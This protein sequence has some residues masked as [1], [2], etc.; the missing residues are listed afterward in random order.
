MGVGIASPA[1]GGER[2]GSRRKGNLDFSAKEG[3]VSYW[4]RARCRPMPLILHV[5]DEFAKRY[6][7]PMS[8]PEGK[9]S[10]TRRLD[11]WSA[12]HFR[13]GRKPYVLA[14]NDASLM[15]IL[16]PAT[17]VT[18]LKKFF[19][20]FLGRVAEVWAEFGAFFDAANQ[21]VLFLPRNNQS[22][23]ESMKAALLL[24][25]LEADDARY[26]RRDLNVRETE[27]LLGCSPYKANEFEAPRKRLPRLLAEGW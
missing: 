22:L 11:A 10:Q 21:S 16:I 13:L 8:L 26:E 27:I 20:L 24:V 15:P 23:M 12:H 6:D 14:M 5:S 7:C 18:T 2:L 1:G 4:N 17:G 9:V 19:P 3:C 25:S